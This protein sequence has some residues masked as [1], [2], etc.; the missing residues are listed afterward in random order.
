MEAEKT[1]HAESAKLEADADAVLREERETGKDLSDWLGEARSLEK[2]LDSEINAFQVQ[3]ATYRSRLTLP[4]TTYQEVQ[5]IQ[6]ERQSAAMAIKRRLEVLKT[7]MNE[8]GEQATRLSDLMVF[9]SRQLASLRA[10]EGARREDEK[11]LSMLDDLT[12]VLERNQ[13]TAK[14]IQGVYQGLISRYEKLRDGYGDLA[15]GIHKALARKHA[16]ALSERGVSPV[17]SAGVRSLRNELAR[18]PGSLAKLATASFWEKQVYGAM[19]SP[20]VVGAGGLFLLVLLAL[21]FRMRAPLLRMG[22]RFD[23][24]TM[25]WA[26]LLVRLGRRSVIPGLLVLFLYFYAHLAN[27]WLNT[28]VLQVAVHCLAAWLFG[29]WFIIAIHYMARRLGGENLSGLSRRMAAFVHVTRIFVIV[30]IVLSWLVGPDCALMA[31]ARP[32]YSAALVLVLAR[33]PRS[34]TARGFPLFS[35]PWKRVPFQVVIYGVG[36]AAM[37][38]DLAG[39]GTF[40]RFWLSSWAETAALVLVA[41]AVLGALVEMDERAR[42]GARDG[43]QD[44]GHGRYP[45]RWL[46]VRIGLLAWLISVVLGA[47]VA[48]GA[49]R[50]LMLM[51]FGTLDH[52]LSVGS[53]RFSLAGILVALLILLGTHALGRFFRRLFTNKV[54]ADSGMEEGLKESITTVFV[55]LLWGLGILFALASLGVQASHMAVVFGAIGIGLGFGL[56]NIFNNFVSGLI[57]LFE[58]PIQVGDSVE[59]NG[60]WA[61][62]KKI[63]VRSTLVQTYDN[64]SLIIPNSDFVSTQVTNW[65]HRD[66]RVRRNIHVGVAYGSDTMLVKKTLLEVARNHPQVLQYP[67]PDVIFLDFGDSA[68]VFRLRIWSTVDYFFTVESEV[69]FEIDRAFREHGITIPFPQRDVHVYGLDRDRPGKGEAEDEAEDEFRV[70]GSKQAAATGRTEDFGDKAEQVLAEHVSEEQEKAEEEHRRRREEEPEAGAGPGRGQEKEK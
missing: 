49:D 38:A 21:A 52:T 55:Y 46:M 32:V 30:H 2:R 9:H 23:P 14:K 39:Y 27:F 70:T 11:K 61:V 6:A 34:L 3:L 26:A 20:G 25:P 45:V 33:F 35:T 48:W 43:I 68:L 44:G 66:L 41:G 60:T 22:Q 12:R 8:I 50:G 4:S 29:R 13:E 10:V 59:I 67:K 17:T 40:A 5:R 18:L 24:E 53:L 51:V 31:V 15:D 7:E 16:Q 65:S 56:Q 54:L 62:V 63:N 42:A 37:V 47:L 28:P 36:L 19:S 1:G 58:R 64:A 57:L 69:R